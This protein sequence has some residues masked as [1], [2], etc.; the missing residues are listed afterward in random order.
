MAKATNPYMRHAVIVGSFAVA[1]LLGVISGGLFAYSP[2]LPE[3]SDLDDYTP[4]TITRIHARSGELIGE[5]ATERRLILSYDEI[6]EVLRNAIISAED[7]DFFNHVGFNIPRLV[8]TMVSNILKGDLTAAGGST[9]TMQVARNVTL[10]GG[11]L[12]LEKTWQR[13]IREAYYTFYIE[14]RYTKREIFTLYCNQMWLGSAN[15]AANGVEAASR[16][17]FGKSAK[18]LELEEAALIA[19]IFQSP[20]RQSPLVNPEEARSRRNYA[21]QR[22]ADE[23]YLTQTEANDAKEKPVQLAQRTRRTNSI[24]PY[25]TEAIR[26]HLEREYGVASLYEEGLTVHTT[27]DARL[28]VAANKAIQAGLRVHDKRH[29]FR[30]PTRNIL[31]E[32]AADDDDDREPADVLTTFSHSQWVFAMNVGDIVP[33]VVTDVD[34]EAMQVRFGPYTARVVPKGLDSAAV[35]PHGRVPG[36]RPDTGGPARRTG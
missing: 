30:P 6:P 33:A 32:A 5:F 13:K 12:G 29:G 36:H 34:D 26:Q 8:M 3:I 21:L 35:R 24:A 7:G 25:F 19:G 16:L 4:G 31:E 1:A 2:D 18:D 11:R 20:S 28:Q 15:H 27:L 10:K 23:G 9:I 22:M 14:K 17:Y